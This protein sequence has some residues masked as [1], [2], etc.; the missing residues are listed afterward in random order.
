MKESDTEDVVNHSGPESCA[1]HGVNIKKCRDVLP[2]L[3]I[4]R[5]LA[6][7]APTSTAT[8]PLR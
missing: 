7:A 6:P 1:E 2:T 8:E 5:D 3:G 4:F